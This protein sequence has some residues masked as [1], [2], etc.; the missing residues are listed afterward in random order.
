[1]KTIDACF[2]VIHQG[3]KRSQR[4]AKHTQKTWGR[5]QRNVYLKQMDETFRTLSDSPSLG[6]GCDYIR[7]GYRKFPQGSHIIYYREGTDVRI[8]IIRVLHKNMDVELNFA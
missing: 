8:E 5:E 6:V 1:M 7:P 3:K 4:H 2:Q